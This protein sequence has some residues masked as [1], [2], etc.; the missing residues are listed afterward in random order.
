MFPIITWVLLGS[1]LVGLIPLGFYVADIT[2]SKISSHQNYIALPQN[3]D[4][5][6]FSQIQNNTTSFMGHRNNIG[7]F[8]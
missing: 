5:R 7:N 3:T 4:N 6:S 8:L 1:G 2:E